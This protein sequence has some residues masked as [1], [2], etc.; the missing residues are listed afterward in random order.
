M[1]RKTR[2]RRDLWRKIKT[3]GFMAAKPINVGVYGRKT[4]KRGV[5]WPQNKKHGGL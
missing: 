1:G 2:K 4:K 5:L 3:R